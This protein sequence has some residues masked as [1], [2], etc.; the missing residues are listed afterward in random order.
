MHYDPS[1][2]PRLMR[3]FYVVFF[4]VIYRITD[5]VVLFIA[6]AQFVLCL[7]TGQPSENL[8]RFSDS[9]GQYVHQIVIYLGCHD[10]QKP[11]PFS[12]WPDASEA[13]DGVAERSVGQ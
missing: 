1:A 9:L 7:V 3:A 10:A 2:E 5:I 4:F 8:R 12:D 13:I 6:V 11:Y